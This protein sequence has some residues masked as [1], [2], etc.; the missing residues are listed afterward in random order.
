[1][2]CKLELHMNWHQLP[3]LSALRAFE[4]YASFGSLQKAGDA[5]SVSHAAISQQIRNLES[6]LN[7]ALLDRT[8]RQAQL[9][10]D[11]E[12][13]ATELKRGFEIIAAEV[14][15]LAIKDADR[16]LIVSTTPS[17][18]ANWLVPRLADFRQ[19]HPQIDVVIDAN[20]SVSDFG[21]S[22][23]DVAIRF[24]QGGWSGVE[25]QLLVATRRFAVAAPSFICDDC[26]TSPSDLARFPLLQEVGTSESSLWLAKHG[27]C[28]AGQGGVTVLPGNLTLDAARMGQGITVTAGVWVQSDIESGRLVKLFEDEEDFGY[29]IVTR[30][31]V[32][33]ASLKAFTKW[34][35]SQV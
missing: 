4:A 19:K 10:E 14:R 3:S 23:P 29:Y 34:L 18:A 16:P 31:G 25:A 21:A 26:P 12:A 35:R 13:L 15:R 7:V 6:H 2:I 22:G 32:Q 11:G 33:R 17:F 30:A 27:V 20:P 24:G 1:M 8:G 9:T 5:L 28:N